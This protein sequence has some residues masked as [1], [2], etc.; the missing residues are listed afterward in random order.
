MPPNLAR[1]HSIE[2]MTAVPPANDGPDRD[3]DAGLIARARA[4]DVGAFEQVYRREVGRGYALCLRMTADAG[5]A[6][7][8]NQSVFVRAWDRPGSLRGHTKLPARLHRIAAT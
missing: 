4:G 5:R 2:S 8:L 6:P 1:K 7:A 3:A